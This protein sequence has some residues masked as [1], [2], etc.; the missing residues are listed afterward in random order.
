MEFIIVK[1]WNGEGYSFLNTA[2]VKLLASKYDAQQLI[3][4][5]LISKL[6]INDI[7][8]SERIEITEGCIEYGDSYNRGTYQWFQKDGVYGIE[9]ICN[10][11]DVIIHKTK[12]DYESAIQTA[13]SQSYDKELEDSDSPFIAAFEGD[14]DYQFVRID[15]N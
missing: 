9:I 5:K 13:L 14:Y 1:T 8:N 3:V 12:Q 10:T 11:N 15:F 6:Q 2:E 7:S 4:S